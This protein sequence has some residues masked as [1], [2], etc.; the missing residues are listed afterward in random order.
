MKTAQV[1][2][3]FGLVAAV[4]AWNVA[5]RYAN[6]SIPLVTET[7]TA[8]TTYCPV[9]TTITTNGKTYTATAS[10]TLTITDCPCTITKPKPTYAPLQPTNNVYVTSVVTAYTTYCP[11]PTTVVQGTATYTVSSATTLTITDCPCTVSYPATT[12]TTVTVSTLTTYCPAPT[13]IVVGTIS[14]PVTTPGTATIP[15]ISLTPVPAS[16][17]TP[18]AP[19]VEVTPAAP[20]GTGAPVAPTASTTGPLQ[21]SSADKV[22][23]GIGALV[24]AVF[25]MLL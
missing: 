21:A 24:A 3:V 18:T 11:A 2:S 5:P 4:N 14:Y 8:L 17:P 22:G 19:A 20:T 12:Y 16:P 7:V 13:T 1:L 9:A 25:A 6:G 15:I 23:S 10:E